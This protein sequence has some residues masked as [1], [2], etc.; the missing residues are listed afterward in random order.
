MN[1][2]LLKGK[3]SFVSNE[4]LKI[5]FYSEDVEAMV[6][7]L[8]LNFITVFFL[9]RV[10]YF[11]FNKLG[12]RR[13]FLFTFFIVGLV[14]FFLGYA[15][16]SDKFGSGVAFGLFAIFSMIR[17]R[18]QSITVKEMAYLFSI[19]GVSLI[20]AL[21]KKI[22]LSWTELGVMNGLVILVVFFIEV[23]IGKNTPAN[24][25]K[26]EIKKE[27]KKS[28]PGIVSKDMVYGLLENVKPANRNAL[29]AD[30]KQK[31]GLDV[32]KVEAK[33]V[34]LKKGEAVLK[35]YYNQPEEY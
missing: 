16:K 6:A 14:T 12:D 3:E 30:L 11:T 18:A 35:V 13:Q 24:V 28:H 26:S 8:L 5:D 19:I 9:S 25:V 33:T 2:L 10:L 15:L 7:L 17:F 34:N 23:M 21:S 27:V 29:I 4:F 22:N 20:N 1:Y 31:T 32:V